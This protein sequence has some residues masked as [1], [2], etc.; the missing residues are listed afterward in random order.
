MLKFFLAFYILLI[1]SS[2]SSNESRIST[3]NISTASLSGQKTINSTWKTT[4]PAN[5]AQ[6]IPNRRDICMDF[7]EK[8]FSSQ[9]VLTGSLNDLINILDDAP[10]K[11]DWSIVQM[12]LK[13][14]CVNLE[15][16]LDDYDDK[17]CKY[18]VLWDMESLKKNTKILDE[19]LAVINSLLSGKNLCEKS[20][21]S[22]NTY[23]TL[24]EKIKNNT[25]TF[26]ENLEVPKILFYSYK[27]IYPNLYDEKLKQLFINDCRNI[28]IN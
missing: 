3:P 22:C 28:P 11:K 23:V 21:E 16:P 27:K 25:L 12:L 13:K 7:V 14:D 4:T 10:S 2:C 9:N 6:S 18:Y 19:D 26:P 5:I 1:L 8:Q 17:I 24:I 15:A 20:S